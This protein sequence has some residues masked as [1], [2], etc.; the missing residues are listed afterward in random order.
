[1]VV[2]GN[3]PFRTLTAPVYV[4]GEVEGGNPDSA[5]AVSLVLLCVALAL[6]GL[7]RAL[8]PLVGGRRG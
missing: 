4:F 7:S 6:A 2:S 5:A 3:I 8:K 1:V